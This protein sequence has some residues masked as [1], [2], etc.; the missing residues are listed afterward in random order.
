MSIGD[1]L[2][3][4][5]VGQVVRIVA[6]AFVAGAVLAGLSLWWCLR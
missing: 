2:V 4:D 1:K 5:L 6:I 3:E